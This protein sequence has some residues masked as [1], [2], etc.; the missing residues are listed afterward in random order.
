MKI[1]LKRLTFFLSF[2]VGILALPSRAQVKSFADDPVKFMED[3]RNFFEAGSTDRNDA[4]DF[5]RKF[6]S[7]Y[8]SIGKTHESK[9]SES[10]KQMTYE[11]CNLMLK[12]RLRPPDFRSYLT[13]MMNFVDTKQSDKNFL[14]WQDCIN[15]ILNGKAIK[16]YTE[17]LSMSENLFAYNVF[18]KS[19]TYEWSSSNNI[20]EF[21][22]DSVPKVIFNSLNLVC[23][24]NQSDSVVINN[25]KGIYYPAT[26]KFIGNGGT[27]NWIKASL[28]PTVVYAELKKY[29]IIVKTGGYTADSVVFYNK[30]YFNKPLQGQLTDKALAEAAGGLSYPRFESYSKRLQINNLTEKV[31]FEGG[32]TMRG[33]KFI[34]SGNNQQA[35]LL[36]FK[37]SDKRFL[38]VSSKQFLITKDKLASD[39]AAIKIFFDTDS[40][41]H[42]GLTFKY[43]YKDKQVSLIRSDDGLARSA[44]LNSYHALDMYFEELTWKTDEPQIQLKMLL[45]NTQGEA[46]FESGG[47]FKAGRYEQLQ[48]MD[49]MNPLVAIK[50]YVKSINDLREFDVGDLARY[51]HAT[52]N[53]LRPL[54]VRLAVMGLLNYDPEQD[55]LQIK[56]RL[57]QYITD[58]VGKTDYDVLNFHSVLPNEANGLINLLNYDLTIKGVSAILLSDSQNVVIYPAARQVVVKKNRD[59]TFAGRIHAGRF[60]FYGKQFAFNYDQFKIDIVDA[61]SMR[62]AVQSREPNERGEFP[63]VKVKSVIEHINGDLLIDHP[64]NKSGYKSYS[65]YPVFNSAKDSYVYYQKRSVQAGVYAK[66]KFYFHLEPFT[67]DSL[68]NFTNAGVN[69]NG[70]FVSAGIFPQFK[71]SL[72]LQKDYSLGFRR[73]TPAEGYALYGGK[74]KFNDTIMLSHEGLQGNGLINYLTST[75]KSRNFIFFPDSMNGVAQTFDVREDKQGRVEF[76]QVKGEGSY[77]HWI[78][79]KDIMQVYSK[80]KPFS[81]YNAKA[82]FTGRYDLTPTLLSGRGKVSFEK[83]ELEAVNIK[84]K[85]TA[86]DSDT[87]DF[88]LQSLE[89]SALAF[90]TSN[91]NAHVDFTKRQ[92]EFK[93]NG[94]GSVVKFPVNQ[95]ICFME[96]FK[97]FMDR[98]DIELGA[99]DK[100]GANDLDLQGPEFIS[101]HPKQDSLRFRAPRAKYDL[102]KYIISAMDVKY[103]DVADA[104]I[105][106]DSGKVI[107]HKDA[108]METLKNA[109]IVANS[110]TKYH[111]VYGANVNIF[112]RKSYSGSGSY[113]YVD[114]LKKK[115]SI[116]FSNITVDTTYQTYAETE[117]KDSTGFTL[118]PNFEYKGKVKL[119]ATNQFLAFTGVTRIQ[120]AC[121]AIKKTWFRFSSEVDPNKIMIP[122]SKDAVDEKGNKLGVGVMLSNDSTHIYSTFLSGK[123]ARNDSTVLGAD[124]FLFYDKAAKE[125]RISN[126]EKLVERNLTGNYVSFNIDKCIMYGEGRL[127]MGTDLGQVKTE[128]VGNA[129]HYMIPDSTAFDLMMTFDFFFEDAALDKMAESINSIGDLKP[130]DFSRKNYEKGLREIL[131]KEKSDKLISQ[132]NLYGV[133]K[134]F[135]DELK[136]S[137]FFTELKMRW[138]QRTH[139]YISQGKIGLGNIQK[140]QINKYVTGRVELVKKRG[141]DILNIYIEGDNSTWY[142][143]NY[144]RGL[145]Q[146]IS[147]L[148]NFNNAIKDLK[149]DKREMKT[150]RGSSPYVFNLST[151]RKKDDFLKRSSSSAT[152]E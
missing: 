20:Y 8:W 22:Y 6:E 71:E 142:Y 136:K 2:L 72:K 49:G 1:T 94:K 54:L 30:T 42:P 24:N 97:W 33:S 117:I 105:S 18:Y 11:V 60:D 114:E 113:D 45:G 109:K 59:F 4:R 74:A 57:F 115:Q 110:V 152:D 41:Y 36:I 64:K 119:L 13:S 25:T 67:I 116:Y 44:F 35:A 131:G 147:S 108:V 75:S 66:D 140:N 146:A 125:Y 89:E 19:P 139:S 150:E 143:F 123:Y 106:P 85:K 7:Q 129:Q 90:S 127:S 102:K 151:N 47:F 95:Y 28:E 34:G 70:E 88:R 78:P 104:R 46:D 51:M 65:K 62:M 130:I 27:V 3:L 38:V 12:K 107:I 43:L 91:V 68:D 122:I 124:G 29:E 15:K 63:Q 14:S 55:K 86:F 21:Q 149:P 148:D 92:G 137:I 81:C 61:D 23:H 80:E 93:S 5:L 69:F 9:F 16:N 112:A 58:R 39:N 133:F 73:S 118:S 77:I 40:I 37:R 50:N 56:D 76:P 32:F 128:A 82:T 132:V 84:F 17:Y 83:A 121:E 52:S 144:S 10:Q 79:Y 134:K 138:N 145:M 141:G 26:G 87:A 53:D 135:P 99:G 111:T 98:S 96:S 126:K 103:I 101:T 120:H 31:D 48:G 100:P